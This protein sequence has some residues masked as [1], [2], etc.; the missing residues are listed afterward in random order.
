MSERIKI[1]AAM[2]AGR[3]VARVMMLGMT[4]LLVAAGAAG[5]VFLPDHYLEQVFRIAGV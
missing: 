2:P 4:G 3:D 1:P 5:M